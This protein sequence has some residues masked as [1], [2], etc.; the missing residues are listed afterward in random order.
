MSFPSSLYETDFFAWANEQAALL[1]A[2][3]IAAADLLHIAEEIE[4]MGKT[5]KRE[6]L[7]RL[8]VLLMHLLKWQYQPNMRG[9]SWRLTIK[10]QR[11]ETA[12]HLSDNPSLKS[13]LADILTDAYG[14]AVLAA[15]R[16]TGLP[17]ETFP[18]ECPW[19]FPQIIEAQFWP[20]APAQS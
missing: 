19:S 3:Q 9:Q 2:G 11:R 7:H 4:S 13:R 16:E 5:E 1:R 18:L 14:D 20:E 12:R 8:K 10:E 6:L 15:A 17:E